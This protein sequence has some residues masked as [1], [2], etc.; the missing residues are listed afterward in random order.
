MVPQHPRASGDGRRSGELW[1][2]ASPRAAGLS[3]RRELEMNAGVLFS[4]GV[5]GPRRWG[6]GGLPGTEPGVPDRRR[7][8]RGR[9]VRVR[10]GAGGVGPHRRPRGA[11][12]GRGAPGP[13]EPGAHQRGLRREDAWRG[14]RHLVGL[15]RD[16]RGHRAGRGGMGGR[17]RLLAMA[18]L[19]QRPAGRIRAQLLRR[20]PRAP[21]WLHRRA[22]PR[23]PRPRP[24]RAQRRAH[25]P[26]CP[27]ALR[28]SPATQCLRSASSCPRATR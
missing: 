5:P 4:A 25:Q 24:P 13:G 21:R 6:A 7:R 2:G 23:P 28:V 15:Q 26:R 12:R 18:V 1:R 8:L 20:R 14:H 10:S 27:S 9:V 11:R 17:A 16:H 3:C 19:L 22:R